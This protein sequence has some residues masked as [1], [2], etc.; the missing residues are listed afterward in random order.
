MSKTAAT[1]HPIHELLARRWS[2]RAF[3]DRDVSRA[4][5]S[6]L[7]EAARWAPSSFNEQPWRFVLAARADA[8]RHASFASCLTPRNQTWAARAPLLAFSCARETFARHGQPNRHAW[9]DVGLATA[10]L[11]LQATH[12]GLSVHLMAGFDPARAREVLEVPE[13][14][15]PV[16]G[17]ALGYAG[18]PAGLP[19]DLQAAERSPRSRLALE[20]LAFE[21][22]W[23][24]PFAERA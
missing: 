6:S 22:R 17:I 21:G 14:W 10:Q 23:G 7:L 5:L 9:H 4:D 8:E 16:A 3:A 11:I 20:E 18:D 1:G 13:G 19:E 15:S 12:L 2:P 24:R